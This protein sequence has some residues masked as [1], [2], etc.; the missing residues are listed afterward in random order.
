MKEELCPIK[1]L[2]CS[3]EGLW[4]L[5]IEKG[6]LQR[7]SLIKND[8][9]DLGVFDIL[10]T[11]KPRAW[12]VTE[13]DEGRVQAKESS[14]FEKPQRSFKSL[15]FI[16][17]DTL[18]LYHNSYN[19]LSIQIKC[20]WIILLLARVEILQKTFQFVFIF[21]TFY[22]KKVR[23]FMKLQRWLNSWETIFKI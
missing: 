23:F 17:F 19:V 4:R 6:F 15:H 3:F 12:A 18:C 21:K 9:W 5:E 11:I 1:S 2:R 7:S 20:I 8:N 22:L 10:Y 13:A 14:S 16:Q